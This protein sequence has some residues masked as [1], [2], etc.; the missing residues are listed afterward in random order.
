M[1]FHASTSESPSCPSTT[2]CDGFLPR[3]GTKLGTT[4]DH[5]QGNPITDRQAHVASSLTVTPPQRPSRFVSQWDCCAQ[6]IRP[7]DHD[8]ARGLGLTLPLGQFSF[9]IENEI[10][11]EFDA[12]LDDD[13]SLWRFSLRHRTT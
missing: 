4:R 7:G 11:V 13:P 2:I 6:R 8:E 1:N 3:W 12:G 9:R 10:I 5:F